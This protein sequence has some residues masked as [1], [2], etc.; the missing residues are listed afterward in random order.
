MCA[1]PGPTLVSAIQ[2]SAAGVSFLLVLCLEEV[3][4]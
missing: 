2:D 1:P 4:K 3:M